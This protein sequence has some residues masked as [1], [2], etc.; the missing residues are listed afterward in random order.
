MAEISRLIRIRILNPLEDV[1]VNVVDAPGVAF[2]CAYGVCLP[3]RAFDIP[4]GRIDRSLVR[5]ALARPRDIFPLFFGRQ[6]VAVTIL[7]CVHS[8]QE[9]LNIVPTD[10]FNRPVRSSKI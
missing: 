1:T 6:T 7:P 9:F 4:G 2:L 3:V 10:L 5:S 8:L